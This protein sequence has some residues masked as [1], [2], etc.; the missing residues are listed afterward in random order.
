M[1]ALKLLKFYVLS[2][3]MLKML[4]MFILLLPIFIVGAAKSEYEYV[5]AD[6]MSYIDEHGVESADDYTQEDDELIP[7]EAMVV[8][9]MLGGGITIFSEFF[10]ASMQC[11]ISRRSSHRAF[12]MFVTVISV[13][14]AGVCSLSQVLGSQHYAGLCES[15]SYKGVEAALKYPVVA[16]GLILFL[17]NIVLGI[18]GS[19]TGSLLFM[20]CSRFNLLQ[21]GG[22]LLSA[23]VVAVGSFI[24]F[25]ELFQDIPGYPEF[26]ALGV[27]FGLVILIGFYLLSRKISLEWRRIMY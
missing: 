22:I 18:L 7:I 2:S 11:G 25:V 12:I 13:I 10:G 1:K 24:G 23:I 6:F 5:T 20:L 14:L 16:N 21:V 19:I 9:G 15:F 8:G 4:L 3:N 27:M 26:I 17:R